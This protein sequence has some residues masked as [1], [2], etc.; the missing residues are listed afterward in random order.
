MHFLLC[1]PF[2]LIFSIVE[3]IIFQVNILDAIIVI[4]APILFTLAIDLLGL[5]LNLWKPKFDWVNETACVKQSMP[6]MLTMFISMGLVFVLGGG[7]FL[8]DSFLSLNAYVYFVLVVIV[9][10]NVFLYYLLMT[11]GIKRFQEL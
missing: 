3:I 6:V 4:V 2:G 9:I 10:I 1:V 5:V 11:W 8:M 7:Y